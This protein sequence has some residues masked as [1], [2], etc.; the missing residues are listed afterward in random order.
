MATDFQDNLYQFINEH[1]TNKGTSRFE[2]GDFHD[3]NLEDY[4]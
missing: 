3:V 2:N 4:H 1:I